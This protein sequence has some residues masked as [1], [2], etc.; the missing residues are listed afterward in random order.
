MNESHNLPC[1][2]MWSKCVHLVFK[3]V[4]LT[5]MHL[6][7]KYCDAKTLCTMQTQGFDLLQPFN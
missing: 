1:Y 5:E 3:N 7:D 2:D 4:K 6:S